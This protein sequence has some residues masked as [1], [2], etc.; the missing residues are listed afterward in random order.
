MQHQHNEHINLLNRI[1]G[2]AQDDET[3]HDVNTN[4]AFE[5]ERSFRVGRRH[6]SLREFFT[7]VV[8]NVFVVEDLF[9]QTLNQLKMNMDIVD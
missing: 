5:K 8:I 3:R 2:K 6:Y 4:S 9:L 1:I 7:N